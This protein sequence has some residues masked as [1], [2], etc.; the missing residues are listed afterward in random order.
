MDLSA[1]V[2]GLAQ[3]ATVSPSVKSRSHRQLHHEYLPRLRVV[4]PT[5]C[6]LPGVWICWSCKLLP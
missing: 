4:K 3:S 1:I 6:T 5:C 2:P